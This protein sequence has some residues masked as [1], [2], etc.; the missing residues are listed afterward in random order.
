MDHFSELYARLNEAQRDAVDHIDG[1]MMVLAGAGTGKT[2]VLA[3][4]IANLLRTTGI[5]PHNIL[6]LTFT[7]AGVTAMRERL[8]RILGTAGYYIKVHTFHS[9]CNDVI[10][11]HP[12][13]FMFAREMVSLSDLEKVQIFQKLLD[14]RAVT[15]ALKTYGSP[16]YYL[17]AIAS[18]ISQL[19]REHVHIDTFT[20][21]V[22]G[23]SEFLER[24]RDKI[25][26]F[27]ALNARD[28]R[29]QDVDDLVGYF[30]EQSEL[31]SAAAGFLFKLAAMTMIQSLA[32]A[33]AN[34]TKQ[35]K[36]SYAG[37]KAS[38]KKFYESLETHFPKHL[39]LIELYRGYQ[40]SLVSKGRYDFDDMILFVLKAFEED[41]ALRAEYQER[42]QYILIDEYQDTNASQNRL[43]RFFG[44]GVEQPNIFVVG[45]D[46]QAIY[47]FQGANLENVVDF[48]T[49][50]SPD[51]KVVTL[52]DNYRSHQSILDVSGRVISNNL[53]RAQLHIPHI[54][55][56]LRAA[57]V[58][59]ASPLSLNIFNNSH[60]ELCWIA[61]RIAKLIIDGVLAE[62]IAVLFRNNS[63]G[64][65]IGRIFKA[66][67]IVH[68]LESG[69]NVFDVVYIRQFINLMK[70]VADPRDNFLMFSLLH[71][72]FL[73]I[74]IRDVLCMHNFS[75]HKRK[76][77]GERYSY[78]EI[79]GS[80]ILLG[81]AG[82]ENVDSIRALAQ[83]I[84]EWRILV[85]NESI[86]TSVEKI[87]HESGMMAFCEHETHSL[88]TL[89]AFK[90]LFE[91]F[92]AH[93]K[94]SRACDLPELLKFIEDH[95]T[96]EI[97][98][99]YYV[100]AVREHAVRL[101]TVHRSKGLEF[102]YVFL[103]QLTDSYWGE[104]GSR[105]KIKL[106]A[107]ILT[108]DVSALA[109]HSIEDERRLF[110]VALTRGKHDVVMSY[111]QHRDDNKEQFPSQFIIEMGDEHIVQ[112][113]QTSFHAPAIVYSDEA[114][115]VKDDLNEEIL[116]GR[117]AQLRISPTNLNDYLKCP[118]LFYYRHFIK[119]P[120]MRSKQLAL[121]TAAH[122]AVESLYRSFQK[123]VGGGEQLSVGGKAGESFQLSVDS[124]QLGDRGVL[125]KEEMLMIFEKSLGKEVLDEKDFQDSLVKGKTFLSA[126][127]D[128]YS[129]HLIKPI[130]IELDFTSHHVMY[131]EIPLTGK[132]DMIELCD[133]IAR[134]VAL[135]DFKTG[136]P[137]HKG[138]D[139]KSGEGDI[140][141]QIVFYKLLTLLSGRF[142]SKYV[143][144]KGVIDFLEPKK[145][146]SFLRKEI[147][148]TQDDCD[149]VLSQVREV[150]DQIHAL[151]FSCR[152]EKGV[153]DFCEKV[154]WDADE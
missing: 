32:E 119:A 55:K 97:S 148:V 47:R 82:V 72:S 21:M 124:L 130:E 114:H 53:F 70:V 112:E 16:Y 37:V 48:Y 60:D 67:G 136:N 13:K 147:V 106:P 125:G 149:T 118:R 28:I 85:Y 8:V 108:H 135:Y 133:P 83:H 3:M 78:F 68:A 79:M 11:E 103:P 57:G 109:K 25:E 40:E 81:E 96:H 51:V 31:T 58:T 98:I 140:W 122:E 117:L 15:D 20:G 92:R 5:E 113:D 74:Q 154:L 42:F 80:E 143:M 115:S 46:D 95:L 49:Q 33:Q 26:A 153:C 29:G 93:C 128:Y 41:P 129:D 10:L 86:L 126:Y 6:C 63:Q 110:Y 64:E 101:M 36:T 89:S 54:V 146:G 134:Q 127:Y 7:E 90:T 99:P 76:E 116:Q 120:I 111:A 66:K 4:R 22:S 138:A 123:S 69:E 75:M 105:E 38:L 43:A 150:W 73:H 139:L 102:E 91:Q 18:S 84:E 24:S 9:F 151:Q 107:H 2:Q 61:D 121:G 144:I 77:N 39:S 137:E 12:E 131:E 88:H 45:D 56:D 14:E 65:A 27:I 62:E 17:D 34:P 100:S 35:G 1:P 145:D 23:E 87:F 50:Y 59:A 142:K 30:Q 19:K 44:E 52:T 94:E 132:V 71:Y 152:D 141:R 104:G